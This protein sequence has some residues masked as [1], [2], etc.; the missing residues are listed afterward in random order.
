M[1][2]ALRRHEKQSEN[3]AAFNHLTLLI[4]KKEYEEALTLSKELNVRLEKDKD[5]PS[6]YACNLLRT[7]FLAEQADDILLTKVTWDKLAMHPLWPQFEPLFQESGLTLH[8]YFMSCN[9]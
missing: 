2:A 5:H 9:Y 6:L 4:E 1:A 7:L 3:V 8:N